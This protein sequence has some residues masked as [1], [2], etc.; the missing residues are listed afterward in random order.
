VLCIDAAPNSALALE[1]AERGGGMA[2]FLTSDP[3]E[4]D[5]ATALDDVLA[6]W[7][8]PVLAGLRLEV[9]RPDV[10]AAGR[11]ASACDRPGW[12][13]IDLG[14][15]PAGRPLWVVGRAPRGDEGSMTLRLATGRGQTLAESR[16]T[17]AGE[18]PEGPALKALFGA[19]QVIALE[20]LIDSGQAP[21]AVRDGLE[22]LGYDAQQVLAGPSTER[23]KVYAE[24]ARADTAEAL[25]SLLVREALGF[26]LAC[27]ETAF[28]AERTEA[29]QA[30]TGRVAVLNALPAGWSE[31]FLGPA[32]AANILLSAGPPVAS[33]MSAFAAPVD[34]GLLFCMRDDPSAPSAA[35]LASL[36]SLFRVPSRARNSGTGTSAPKVVFSGVPAPVGGEAVLFDSTT[37]KKRGGLPEEATLVRLEVRFPEGMPDAVDPGLEILIFVDD[38]TAPRARVRLADLIKQRGTRPLNLQ[39]ES[40]Q[41]VR[42][43]LVDPAGAWARGAPRIE[44]ALAW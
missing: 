20:H 33:A 4:Q 26:G 25:R 21:D 23:S 32:S 17:L 39:K 12:S 27:S 1:L 43:S 35:R 7:S 30:V 37:A 22:R 8:E 36:S 11:D 31:D 24:N 2:R 10:T 44:V 18:A 38:V 28:I 19:R 14:D 15:L 41:P 6:D 34:A 9:D 13:A 29:G 3:K 16:R 5:I 42:I 40:G